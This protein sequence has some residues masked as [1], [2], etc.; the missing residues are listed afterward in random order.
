LKC[1]RVE[2]LDGKFNKVENK[3]QK[4]EDDVEIKVLMRFRDQETL[5]EALNSKLSLNDD[6]NIFTIPPISDVAPAPI[7]SASIASSKTA[8]S[9]KYT[10]VKLIEKKFD[11]F[12]DVNSSDL[13]LISSEPSSKAKN[14]LI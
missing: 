3:I 9:S 7:Q 2:I 12:E 6:E 5:R 8:V 4:I 13:N 14:T 1:G 11:H 10:C